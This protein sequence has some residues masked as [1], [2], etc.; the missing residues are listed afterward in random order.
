MTSV[1]DAS[2]SIAAFVPQFGDRMILTV[3]DVDD[4]ELLKR[5]S[6]NVGVG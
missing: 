6:E 2:T 1:A 4:E 5:D 3:I